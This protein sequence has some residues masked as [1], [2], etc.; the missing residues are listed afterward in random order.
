LS[1]LILVLLLT[2]CGSSSSAGSSSGAQTPAPSQSQQA[3]TTGQTKT[4]R[5]PDKP[6]RYPVLC[7]IHQFMTGTLVLR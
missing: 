3:G 5:A 6:G 1:G 7:P 4:F 2:A